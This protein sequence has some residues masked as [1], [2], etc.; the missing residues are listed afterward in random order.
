M[1]APHILGLPLVA[2]VYAIAVAACGSSA[3]PTNSTSSGQTAGVRL[4][5][6][7]RSHGV[8]AFPDPTAGEPVGQ[9]IARAGVDPQ[10][11]AVQSAVGACQKLMQAVKNAGGAQ[12]TEARK[13]ELVNLARCLRAHGLSASVESTTS[14]SPA[15][16]TGGGIGYSGP[17]G[18]VSLSVPESAI[19]S[20]AFQRAASACGF[21]LPGEAKRPAG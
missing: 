1:R 10:S 6:C 4:A 8:P 14:T 17:G 16:P 18:S 19:Q 2:C 12:K 21:P 7:M 5:E 11:P 20:P 13:I 15:P 9:L 3:R